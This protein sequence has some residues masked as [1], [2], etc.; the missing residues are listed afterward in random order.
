VNVI[1]QFKLGYKTTEFWVAV[2][3][4]LVPVVAWAGAAVG[5]DID[6]A[7][8][9]ASM[10]GMAPA[11]AYILG[12]SWLKKSRVEALAAQVVV[13]SDVVVVPDGGDASSNVGPDGQPL[14]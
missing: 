11:F 5:F 8:L 10:I 2:I 13:N 7:Q 14:G 4:G 3:T 12:R 1:D 9:A 6:S